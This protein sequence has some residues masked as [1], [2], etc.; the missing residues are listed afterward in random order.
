MFENEIKD[1]GDS[2]RFSNFKREIGNFEIACFD[3]FSGAVQT[4]RNRLSSLQNK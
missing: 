4:L 2:V 1:F 3:E